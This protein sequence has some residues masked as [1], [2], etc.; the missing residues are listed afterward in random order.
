V[1]AK[2]SIEI[3]PMKIQL[4]K[5]TWWWKKNRKN[6]QSRKTMSFG[7]NTKKEATVESRKQ[8]RWEKVGKKKNRI[9][10]EKIRINQQ[11]GEITENNIVGQN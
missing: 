8:L 5:K 4:E 1:L 10:V 2:Y 11:I 9:A 7:K 3:K 6:R